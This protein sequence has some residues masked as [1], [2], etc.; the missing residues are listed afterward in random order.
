VLAP[1]QLG[2][3][4]FKSLNAEGQFRPAIQFDT[5]FGKQVLFEYA[6]ALPRAVVLHRWEVIEN[7]EQVLAR[8]V[9][10]KF[11][12]QNTVLLDSAPSLTAD[13]SA[14]ATSPVQVVR[15]DPARVELRAALKSP[16]LLLLTDHYDADWSATVDGAPATMLRANFIM[17]AVALPPGEHSVIF[18]F[19]AQGHLLWLAR[20]KWGVI[21]LV[22]IATAI[23]AVSRKAKQ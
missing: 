16:G 8:L 12:P 5:A 13:P 15:F 10:P 18:S 3:N 4:F 21:G 19:R 20:I 1:E 6:R 7:P 9:E 2:T 11:N 17:R 22:A 14:P 23:A